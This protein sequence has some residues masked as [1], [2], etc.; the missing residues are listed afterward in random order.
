MNELLRENEQL[1]DLYKS[2]TRVVLAVSTA[3]CLY[4]SARET[5]FLSLWLG[6]E[7]AA[8]SY[9]MLVI[10]GLAF[11]FL[12]YSA[13]SWI[14]AEAI[15]FPVLNAI[16][17]LVICAVAILGM[18]MLSNYFGITGVAVGRLVGAV[19]VLPFILVVEKRAFGSAQVRFWVSNILILAVASAV[20][21]VIG[22]ALEMAEFSVGL[23]FVV[24]A[25]VTTAAFLATLVLLR[26]IS[27][28]K[29][30]NSMRYSY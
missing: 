14:L 29:L 22:N 18:M 21:L 4:L 6:E 11:T 9:E 17:S 16:I 20:A 3:I 10:H 28:A 24:N 5:P 12:A 25:S 19:V 27:L 23:Q 26:F 2:T 8:R 1:L 30:W 7:F 15:H 13:I